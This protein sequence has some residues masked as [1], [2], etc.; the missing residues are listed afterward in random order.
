[1]SFAERHAEFL[2]QRLR[3]FG[4]SV[5]LARGA[6][7]A[8]GSLPLGPT[9]LETLSPR[10]I[11]IERVRFYT[12]GHNRLKL[13]HPAIFFD[14]PALDVT[15]CESAADIEAVLR[16][17][18]AS[19]L[20]DLGEALVWLQ[21]VRAPTE[22]AAGGARLR[23]LDET[24]GA[25]EVRSP[26]ELLLP[27]SG[28]LSARSLTDPSER[29]YRPLASL[30][31]ANDLALSIGSAMRER[32]ARS[33]LVP[34]PSPPGDARPISSKRVRRVLAVTSSPEALAGLQSHLAER[35]IELDLL[36]DPARGLAAFRETSYPLLFIDVRL[37]RA[38]GFEL[39][40][41][42]RELPGLETLPIVLIDERESNANRS[43]A[44]DAGAAL[45]VA[46]PLRWEELE[47][48]LLDLLDHA[49]HRR[50]RRFPARLV[51][52]TD[53]TAENWDELTELV[54][55]G[56]VCLRTRRDILP[57]AVERYRIDLPSPFAPIEVEG[58][59]MS[60]VT[61]PGYASVLAGIRF[62]SF[63]DGGEPRWIRVIEA[64]AERS[65]RESKATPSRRPAGPS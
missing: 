44:R 33:A 47:K 28:E 36:R 3:A 9:P 61:L 37:G 22:L 19:A 42:F 25:I 40:M 54:A 56:G 30:E 14:L 23:F 53:S 8:E 52:H 17:A 15:R 64:L 62:R 1:M 34:A 20:R 26:R 12:L 48:P 18:W 46:K 38:D 16:R 27:S 63:L 57:G 39:A 49:A 4:L 50:Y 11:V 24:A 10:P 60:R 13:F 65:D 31:T 6:T 5:E 45:Y 7:S 41:R 59:V 55:R 29:R 32:A 35:S 21:R 43:A 58:D 51:V 2:V